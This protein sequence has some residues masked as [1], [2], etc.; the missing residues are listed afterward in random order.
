MTILQMGLTAFA[1]VS[2]VGSQLIFKHWVNSVGSL[3]LSAEGVGRLFVKILGSPLMLTGLVLYGLGFLA[4]IL[5]LS[6][7]SLSLVYPV[8]ISLN[9]LLIL[10]LSAVFFRESI[11]QLQILGIFFVLPGIFLVFKI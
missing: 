3:P 4:W 1:V 11:Y 5:L 6:R 2:A 9:I 7:T 10:S 8:V